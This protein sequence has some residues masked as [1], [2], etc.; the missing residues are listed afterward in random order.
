MCYRTSKSNGAYLL[1]ILYD[2]TVSPP[3]FE[4]ESLSDSPEITLYKWD[5]LSTPIAA[6]NDDG[7]VIYTSEVIIDSEIIPAE[8][9]RAIE[10]RLY[11]T[12]NTVAKLLTPDELVELCESNHYNIGESPDLPPV[13][14]GVSRTVLYL[15][16]VGYAWSGMVSITTNP[17]GGEV[18]DIWVM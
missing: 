11:G 10:D 16:G 7:D 14:Y 3:E 6:R 2:L 17:Q 13:E 9:M 12:D 18:S 15:D 1:H 5:F 8:M 4:R